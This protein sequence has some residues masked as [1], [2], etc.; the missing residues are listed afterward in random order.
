MKD[1][2]LSLL[3]AFMNSHDL[4]DVDD[5]LVPERFAEWARAVAP[6]GVLDVEDDVRR[7]VTERLSVLVGD[8][9]IFAIEELARA[10]DI[11]DGLI[12]ILLD[13]DESAIPAMSALVADVPVRMRVEPTGRVGVEPAGRGPLAIAAAALLLAHDAAVDGTWGRVHLCCAD[14]CHW[15]FVDR[16][17]NGSRRWCSMGDC[18][19]R[20]KARAYRERR[21]GEG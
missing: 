4:N 11:R 7:A 19:S 15:A 10:R 3:F 18:G 14:D 16:S 13:G 6:D 9:S 5:W 12:A 2:D 21:R 20:A 17:R 8:E 1:A